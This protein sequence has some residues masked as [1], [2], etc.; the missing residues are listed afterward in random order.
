M[1]RGR[2]LH[3]QGER[4]G[5]RIVGRRA[6]W[7]RVKVGGSV[8]VERPGRTQTEPEH[9]EEL[10]RRRGPVAAAMQVAQPVEPLDREG[11][12]ACGSVYSFPRSW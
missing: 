9:A 3:G 6:G 4:H 11:E 2:H 5:L 7:A 12:D 1:A 8:G 10:D